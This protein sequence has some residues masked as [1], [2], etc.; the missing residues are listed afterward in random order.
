MD[1]AHLYADAEAQG[2][3]PPVSQWNPPFCG[4]IDMR[5]RHDGVWLHNGTAIT[6][7]AMVRLFSRILRREDD[8]YYL[9][10]P[11]E[12]VGITVEDVPF[13]AVEMTSDKGVLTFR[14]NVG[15]RVTAD[16]AHPLR[17]EAEAEAFRPY[18]CVRDGL[19][20]RLSRSLAQ[21]L[22]AMGEV[23][24]H[25]GEPWFGIPSGALFFP[26]IPADRL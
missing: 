12:K 13:I 25:A 16:E 14:T 2:P 10:T 18:I 24:E 15:D 6:R 9:V 26:V 22:A 8:A 19:E 20:A 5:I 17:L 23:R 4:D 3:L 11:V 21:E 7:P 1:L